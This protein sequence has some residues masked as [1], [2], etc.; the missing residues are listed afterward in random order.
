M[1]KIKDVYKNI[2]TTAAIISEQDTLATAQ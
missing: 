2:T 1:P